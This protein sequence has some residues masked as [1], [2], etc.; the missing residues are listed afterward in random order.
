LRVL[1]A[2]EESYHVY[3]AVMAGGLQAMRPHLQLETTG[4]EEFQ[5]RRENFDPQVVICGGRAFARDERPLVWMDLAFDA[6]VPFNRPARI[7][8]GGHCREV[9]NPDLHY[10]LSVID[11][12]DPG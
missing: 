2:M 7:W 4:L 1:I 11:E 12:I 3:R 9:H 5:E 10:L 8:I 6:A